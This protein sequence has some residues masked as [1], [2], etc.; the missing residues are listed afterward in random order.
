[1]QSM[2]FFSPDLKDQ[3]SILS[4]LAINSYHR[5]SPNT[6]LG[7]FITMA[8]WQSRD[9]GV[10]ELENRQGPKILKKI[11]PDLLTVRISTPVNHDND[12]YEVSYYEFRPDKDKKF[13]NHSLWMICGAD[14]ELDPLK[15]M[16]ASMKENKLGLNIPT[17]DRT[18]RLLEELKRGAS[19]QYFVNLNTNNSA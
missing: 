12:N 1:M 13:L 5:F 6:K 16:F 15:Y 7:N 11:F 3:I 9:D 2:E 4:K 8:A 18:N 14:R 17:I 19:S 10:V